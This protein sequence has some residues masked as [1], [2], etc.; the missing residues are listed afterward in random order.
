MK[1]FNYFQTSEI[2]YGKGRIQE[3][4]ELARR[5]GKRCLLVTPPPISAL[6]P[7]FNK[8]KKILIGSGLKVE[9]FDKVEPNPTTDIVTAGAEMAEK[10]K[11]DIVIGVGGGSSMDTAKAIAVEATHKGTAWDYLYFRETQPTEKTL[12]IIAVSTTSGTG[13]QV[14]QVAVVTNTKERNKS[15]IFNSIIYP[16]IAIVDPE[17]MITLP[18]SVTAPTGFDAFCHAFESVVHI[19]NSPIVD[20]L[21]WRA[22][23]IVINTLPY[24]LDNLDDIEARSKL[25]LADTLAGLSIANVGVTLPHGIG[26]AISG[27]YPHI[28][29]GVSLAIVYPAFT[30]FT[31]KHALP[32]FAQLGRVF[33]PDMTIEPDEKMAEKS[34]EDIDTFLKK[35]GLSKSLKDYGMPEEEIELLAKNSMILPDYK[36]NPRL[37]TDKE[38]LQIIRDSY[39]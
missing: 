16:K 14:T 19:N 10:F 13:S 1:K 8:V 12:P 15:A 37:A 7:L 4:G 38:M 39:Y 22:I 9:H 25:A 36:N 27:L 2:V 26:M 33:N 24:L 18:K 5:F 3:L 35:I 17:L 28:A 32:Q 30:R 31:Y 20:V 21:A 29:H 6:E 34:I 23:E 11:A